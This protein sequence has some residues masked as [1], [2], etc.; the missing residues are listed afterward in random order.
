MLR[1]ARV[2]CAALALLAALLAPLPVPV[3]AA[4]QVAAASG[5]PAFAA[6]VAAAGRAGGRLTITGYH[7]EGESQP[8]T[9]ELESFEVWHPNAVIEVQSRPNAPPQRLPRPATRYFKGYIAGKPQSS[10]LLSI[11]ANGAVAGMAVHGNVSWA[12]GR[13]GGPTAAAAPLRSHKARAAEAAGR[14]PFRCGVHGTSLRGRQAQVPATSVPNQRKLHQSIVDK[15]YQA[16]IALE[17][18]AEF[19]NLFKSGA[20]ATDYVGDLIGYADVVYGR[21]INTD[22]LISYLRLWNGGVASDPWSTTTDVGRSLDELQAHWNAKMQSTPR[23]VTHMLSGQQNGGGIAYIGVLCDW[24][25]RPAS[26]YAYG[27]TANLNGRFAWDENQAHNPTAFGWDVQSVLHELGHNFNSPHTQD[28]CGIGG[29]PNTV[30][31]CVPSGRGCSQAQQYV[32]PTCTAT[33]TAFGGG[34]GTLMSYCHMLRGGSN[35]VVR[36]KAVHLPRCPC[37]H[38]VVAHAL[39]FGKNHPCGN[40]PGRVVDVMRAHV[41][42]Q[43]QQYPSCLVSGAPLPTPVPSPSPSPNPSPSPAPAPV[44]SWGRPIGI[45]TTCSGG[46]CRWQSSTGFNRFFSGTWPAACSYSSRP[47]V[48]FRWYSGTSASSFIFSSCSYTVGDAAVSVLSSPNSSRGPWQCVARND[49]GGC[50]D[51]GAFRIRLSVVARRYY[52]FAVVPIT[53]SSPPWVRP[54]LTVYTTATTGKR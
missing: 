32:L 9:L 18:D 36:F 15:P 12:L 19:Y 50:P 22:M 3:R 24:Y 42:T 2:H 14:P 10:V 51:T 16:S 52:F 34:P 26:N 29:N 49:Y 43:A 38:C 48:V 41:A 23:T 37:M 21:E 6:A 11:R 54:H 7:L 13:P 25:R 44:G 30:D 40:A 31:N 33:P 27:V 1:S 39:T 8:D 20:A 45:A 53:P 4:P 17:T 5:A 46:I 47:A 28:Y 35:N